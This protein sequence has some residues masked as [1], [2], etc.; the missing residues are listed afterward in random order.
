MRT[1]VRVDGFLASLRPPDPPTSA[2]PAPVALHAAG[3]VLVSESALLAGALAVLAL[4]VAAAVG[5][6]LRRARQARARER[7]RAAR[8]AQ[9]A[10]AVRP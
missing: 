2:P 3:H 4:L 10:S 7:V 5:L 9:A 1:L 6:L 8:L